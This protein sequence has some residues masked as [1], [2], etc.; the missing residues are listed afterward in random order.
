MTSTSEISRLVWVDPVRKALVLPI[1]V[2][3]R[4]AVD[5]ARAVHLGLGG[6]DQEAPS[7]RGSNARIAL[8][9]IRGH[10]MTISIFA[11]KTSRDDGYRRDFWRYAEHTR[12]VVLSTVGPDYD[13]SWRTF[14]PDLG[15]RIRSHRRDMVMGLHG[16]RTLT[17]AVR[18]ADLPDPLVIDPRPVSVVKAMARHFLAWSKVGS[19]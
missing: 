1:V 13:P 4:G 16:P 14:V 5:F 11:L 6:R 8:P 3:G 2:G 12:W 17:E 18:A 9:P 15:A 10:D 19:G 7:S